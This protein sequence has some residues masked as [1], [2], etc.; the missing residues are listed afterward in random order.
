MIKKRGIIILVAV[1]LILFLIFYLNQ[2]LLFS[3]ILKKYNLSQEY[4]LEKVRV[5][6][7]GIYNEDDSSSINKL[8]SE[9]QEIFNK[10]EKEGGKIYFIFGNEDEVTLVSY[11]QIFQ[12][13]IGI[14]LGNQYGIFKI[15]KEDYKTKKFDPETRNVEMEIEGVRY[16]FNLKRNE[17]SYFILYQNETK[18]L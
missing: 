3:P 12:G 11:E 8:I 2:S 5:V 18:K 7:Y 4:N 14:V 1:I 17:N 15:R 9:S 10:Y 6:G 16:N 13:N